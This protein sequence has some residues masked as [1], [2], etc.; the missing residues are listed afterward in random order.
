MAPYSCRTFYLYEARAGAGAAAEGPALEAEV[1]EG[2]FTVRNGSLTLTHA[3][4]SPDLLSSITAAVAATEG[5]LPLGRFIALVNQ[6]LSQQLWVAAD[7]ADSLRCYR[8]PVRFAADVVVAATKGGGDTKTAAD[9][10]GGYAPQQARPHHFRACY[11]LAVYPGVAGFTSRLL[12]IE[13]RDTEPWRVGSYYH[14]AVSNIGG[15]GANDVPAKAL[16]SG[17]V[18]WTN[19]KLGGCLGFASLGTGDFKMSYW[20]DAAPGGA[21]HPDVWR[22]LDVML[23][24]GQRYE[25]P[26]P[27]ARFFACGTTEEARQLAEG[28]R[29]EARAELR[30]FAA[31]VN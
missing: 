23:A 24:P 18:A 14:Y 22:D 17:M 20:R 31:E 8:G 10:E 7:Q 5:E 1:G 30:T 26:Q 3:A 6:R 15:D 13:N 25:A 28:F 9:Q 4:G 2:S 21:E 16:P 11:R 19:E 27:V 29:A 12:W